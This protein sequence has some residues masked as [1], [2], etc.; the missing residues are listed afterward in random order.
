M[1]N[2]KYKQLREAIML[3][4][5]GK[6]WYDRDT[7]PLKYEKITLCDVLIAINENHMLGKYCITSNGK[8]FIR[9]SKWTLTNW[10]LSK[11]NFD[12]QSDETKESLFNLICNKKLCQ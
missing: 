9:G 5:I 4:Q 2:K 7:C 1:D 10:N 8:F 6:S 11:N 12:D 3:A